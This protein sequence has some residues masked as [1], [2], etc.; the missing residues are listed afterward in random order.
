LTKKNIHVKLLFV[1][2]GTGVKFPGY[3]VTVI[4]GSRARRSISRKILGKTGF[5]HPVGGVCPQALPGC[6]QKAA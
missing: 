2:K 1:T 5:A 3:S 4:G 6:G